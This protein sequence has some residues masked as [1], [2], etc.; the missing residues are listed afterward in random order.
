[1]LSIGRPRLG[2]SSHPSTEWTQGVREPAL[3]R[4]HFAATLV[5]RRH[6]REEAR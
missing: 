5:P 1:M 6:Q 3:P 4:E 2:K